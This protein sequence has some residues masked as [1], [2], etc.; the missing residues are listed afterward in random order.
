MP[1]SNDKAA[2]EH[3]NATYGAEWKRA[4]AAALA[5]AGRRCQKCSSTQEIQV[6]HVIPVSQGGSHAASNLQVLCGNCHRHKTA[7]EGSGY[8]GNRTRKPA[9]DPPFQPRTQW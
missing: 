9:P 8:R 7:T 2:R 4:R 3:S 5:R 1:W 6:D